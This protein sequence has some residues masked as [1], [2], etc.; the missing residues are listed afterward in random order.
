MPASSKLSPGGVNHCSRRR[1]RGGG[2]AMP[3][4]CIS[5]TAHIHAATDKPTADMPAQEIAI[6]M[7]KPCSALMWP[8]VWPSV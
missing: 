6:M 5:H 7:K 3:V 4:S 1:W 8:C 2:P